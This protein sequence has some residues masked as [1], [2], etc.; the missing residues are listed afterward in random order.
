MVLDPTPPGLDPRPA[1]FISAGIGLTPFIAMLHQ[2]LATPAASRRPLTIIHG[3]RSMA[4]LP[5]AAFLTHVDRAKLARVQIRFSRGEPLSDARD[6]SE[7]H[8]TGHVDLPLIVKM[9]E[10]RDPK[11]VD[12]FLCGP[13]DFMRTL[14]R[15][16]R[17]ELGVPPGHV[18]CESF[19]SDRT[20]GAEEPLSLEDWLLKETGGAALLPEAEE[21]TDLPSIMSFKVRP[22]YDAGPVT[23]ELERE[24]SIKAPAVGEGGRASRDITVEFRKSKRKETWVPGKNK[25]LLSFGEGLGLRM[26]YDCRYDRCVSS[27]SGCQSCDGS[28]LVTCC[29]RVGVCGSCTLK[30]VGGHVNCPV[31]RR[32]EVRVCCAKPKNEAG[33][34]VIFDF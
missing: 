7:N 22:D 12:F 23:L 16:L 33:N 13:R 1:V 2:Q 9:L 4:E 5:F 29:A 28:L 24:E 19:T 34:A 17:L 3:E 26:P 11:A 27:L 31:G 8:S 6:L 21:P 25:D 32:G 30:L 14:Y 18:M 10:G 20:A 15:G